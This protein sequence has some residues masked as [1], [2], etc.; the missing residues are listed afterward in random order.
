MRRNGFCS[1][2]RNGVKSKT[3]ATKTIFARSGRHKSSS[4]LLGLFSELMLIGH[5]RELNVT[6]QLSFLFLDPSYHLVLLYLLC[7]AAFLSLALYHQHHRLGYCWCPHYTQQFIALWGDVII[8]ITSV[9]SLTPLDGFVN[10]KLQG[11]GS[12]CCPL[13][14]NGIATP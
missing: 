12:R 4:R 8:H 13:L 7:F 9:T 2:I 3:E 6:S 1:K 5:R 10:P 14:G 11:S